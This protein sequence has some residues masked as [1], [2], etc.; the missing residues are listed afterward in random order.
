M[1]ARPGNLKIS[2]YEIPT[3]MKSL[4]VAMIFGFFFHVLGKQ[5]DCKDMLDAGL[6]LAGEILADFYRP[7]LGVVLEFVDTGGHANT[8]LDKG[9][10]CVPGHVLEAMWF[11]ISI[12]EVYHD[13]KA[14]LTCCELIKRH[15][16]LA[17]DEVYG[18]LKLAIDVQGLEPV[19]WTTPD[20]K[21]WWVQLEALVA[22]TLAYIHT[23]DGSFIIW[24]EKI[25]Q[26]A[27]NNYPQ[28]AGEWTQ[29]LDRK[30]NKQHSVALPV[31]DP[32]HLPRAMI[33][34]IDLFDRRIPLERSND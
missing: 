33:Y 22:T 26:W 19:S 28:A 24:H 12:F 7:E 2:P 32:F 30:G 3:G 4:G 20:C 18:G 27:Y 1:L 13:K 29:W 6:T 5:L 9:R 21:P 8:Q 15:L 23:R 31:K 25:K 17:W 10:I 34:L 16:E 11:L 14:I